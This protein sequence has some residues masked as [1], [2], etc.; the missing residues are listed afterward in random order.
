MHVFTVCHYLCGRPARRRLLSFH[1]HQPLVQCKYCITAAA[2]RGWLLP[3]ALNRDLY[4]RATAI[5]IPGSVLTNSERDSERE[6]ERGLRLLEHR[7]NILEAASWSYL[8]GTAHDWSLP[9][10]DAV[11]FRKY[12]LNQQNI[13]AWSFETSVTIHQSTWRNNEEVFMLTATRNVRN[14]HI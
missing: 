11:Y 13:G 14:K 6:R 4:R 9:G 3:S 7:V 2:A 12:C 1:R 8:S 10:R 5:F